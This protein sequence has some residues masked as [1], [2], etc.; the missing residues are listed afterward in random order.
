MAGI[1]KK[2]SNEA[3]GCNGFNDYNEW[4][5]DVATGNAAQ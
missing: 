4:K 5:I 1:A 3:K 2:G